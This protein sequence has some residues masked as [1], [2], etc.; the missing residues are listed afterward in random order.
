MADMVLLL[1]ATTLRP[2][3][4]PLLLTDNDDGDDDEPLLVVTSAA[5]VDMWPRMALWLK[6]RAFALILSLIPDFN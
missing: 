1:E 3:T 4:M 5:K 6:W 2:L